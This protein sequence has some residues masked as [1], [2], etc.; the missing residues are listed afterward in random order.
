[1]NRDL[2]IDIAK[3]LAIWA[4]VAG[5]LIPKGILI[6]KIIY[7][8]HIP[9]FFMVSGY[10]HQVEPGEIK[11]LKKKI[12]SF[13]VP[14]LTYLLIFSLPSI[15]LSIYNLIQSPSYDSISSF[16]KY[17]F[18][19]IYGGQALGGDIAVFWFITCL[20][21]TGQVF[22]FI[23]LRLKDKKL[24]IVVA[25][26]FYILAFFNQKYPS[27]WVLPWSANVVLCSFL[28]YCFGA[29]YGQYIFQKKNNY[30]LFLSIIICSLSLILMKFGYRINFDMKYINYGTFII[31]PLAAI[32]WIKILIVFS[33]FLA[34]QNRLKPFLVFAGTASITVMFLHEFFHY[35]L[36]DWCNKWPW[37]M[38]FVIFTICCMFHFIFQKNILS[39]AF[40]LG[41]RKDF[42]RVLTSQ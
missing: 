20:F 21:L 26:V 37:F 33:D 28:F 9:F 5:H 40:L 36:A 29:F 19:L 11:Y 2:K 41:S 23:S 12:I 15:F 32:A 30:I 3:G 6:W 8:F 4:V 13:L 1:M 24:I 7:I 42:E 27:Y 35:R 31:S 39:R 25:L 16:L 18:K 22:N 10:F 17:L 34:T 38:T 14:Y